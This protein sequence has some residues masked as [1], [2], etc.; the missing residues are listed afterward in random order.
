MAK[1]SV[2]PIVSPLV[3]KVAMFIHLK[4][5]INGAE[6]KGIDDTSG[7]TRQGCR[8]LCEQTNA[9]DVTTSKIS[10]NEILFEGI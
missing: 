7:Q 4:S 9:L 5:E 3:E 1:V 6:T 8:I 10:E 2:M